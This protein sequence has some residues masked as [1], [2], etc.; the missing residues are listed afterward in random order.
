MFAHEAQERAWRRMRGAHEAVPPQLCDCQ[1]NE[2]GALPLVPRGV[3][4]SC[5]SIVFVFMFILL[6]RPG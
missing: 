2:Y 5:V 4:P 6:N 3:G 1:Y